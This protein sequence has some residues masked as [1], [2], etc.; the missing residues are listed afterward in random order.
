MCSMFDM[1]SC[2]NGMKFRKMA[3][4]GM[5]LDCWIISFESG[6]MHWLDDQLFFE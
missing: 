5:C 3:D 2:R 1:K 4:T 6:S